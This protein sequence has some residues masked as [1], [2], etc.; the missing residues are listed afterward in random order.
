M[1]FSEVVAEVIRITKRP[2]KTADIGIAINK[3]LTYCTL[4]GSFDRDTVEASLPVTDP[5][6][7]GGTLDIST[8]TRFRRF[9]YIKPTA[10]K[11]YL[12]PLAADKIF[13]PKNNMQ[14]NKYYIV[15][16]TLTYTLSELTTVLEVGYL[17]YPL[18][19]DASVNTTHWMMDMMPYAIIDL[20][21]A[22]VFAGIG[23]DASANKHQVF[24]MEQYLTLRKDLSQG[25]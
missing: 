20:A 11:Y 16:Q 2:D 15:G 8:F 14:P 4:K 23:D 7:Y 6:A 22:Y 21:A 17:T 25:E 10:K 18:T 1:N 19:V 13:T 9:T 5:L 3:A 24:G 12:Q